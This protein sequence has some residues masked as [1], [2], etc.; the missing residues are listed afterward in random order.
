MI[1]DIQV[2]DVEPC[3]YYVLAELHEVEEVTEGGIII[4]NATQKREQDAMPIATIKKIGPC[5]FR[6]SEFAESADDWGY[7]VGDTVQIAPHDYRK[8]TGENKLVLFIDLNVIARVS[9]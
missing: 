3:G 9:V 8:V 2:T 7:K 4:Q 5:A 1:K 6:N